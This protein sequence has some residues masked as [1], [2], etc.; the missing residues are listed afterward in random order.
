MSFSA[1]EQHMLTNEGKLSLDVCVTEKEVVV[2]APMAGVD[3]ESV[4]VTLV[5]DLLTIRGKRLHPLA[6]EPHAP[7]HTE[8]F[9]GPFSRSV[10][11]PVEVLD[12]AARAECAQGLLIIRVPRRQSG[13]AIPVVFV[14]E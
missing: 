12:D 8:C 1:A 4:D 9:W 10:L 2:L 7:A 11:L 3:Q 13:T 5:D 14:D 6:N